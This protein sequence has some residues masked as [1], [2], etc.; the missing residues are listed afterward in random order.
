[1]KIDSRAVCSLA[2]GGRGVFTVAAPG[3]DTLQFMCISDEEAN[4]W[5]AALA[6]AR[7]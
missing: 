5:L 7:S 6:S 2:K 4:E 3:H 1:V